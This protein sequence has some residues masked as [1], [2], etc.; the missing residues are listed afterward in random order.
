VNW[1]YGIVKAL[2]DWLRETPPPTVRQGQAPADLQAELGAAIAGDAGGAGS[3][4]GLRFR[5]K[6]QIGPE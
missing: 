4:Q 3:R 5:S 2:L 1:V 6:W